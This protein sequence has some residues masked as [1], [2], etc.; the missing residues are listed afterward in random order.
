[1]NDSTVDAV[2]AL[3]AEAAQT[4]ILPRFRNLR[5]E[6]IEDKSPTLDRQDLVT[7]V[8]RDVELWL[9]HAFERLE[10]GAAVIGEEAVFARPDLLSLIETDQ[11]L[12]IIDPIDGT[13]NFARGDDGFGVMVARVV[14]GQTTAAWLTLPARGDMFV[15]VAGAGT[16]LNGARVH[17][18]LAPGAEC[19]RGSMFVRHMP[20]ELRNRVMASATQQCDVVTDSSCAAVEYTD[21]VRGRRD[22]AVYY[23][24]LPWDHA[25]P[26]LILS[27]AGGCVDHQSG[28]R[29]S[30][31]SANQVTVVARSAEVSARV[32]ER[33]G[34]EQ[35]S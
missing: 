25:A 19:L 16:C 5:P 35:A 26:A 34:G 3:I 33:L 23:R 7:A 13:K 8:D 22:F 10:P 1:M 2:T 28:A 9:A 18:P 27:E 17:V 6:D 30:V 21:V 11:P 14:A 31:R 29:Y 15:A 24:L 12:W 4:L 32:R 20:S